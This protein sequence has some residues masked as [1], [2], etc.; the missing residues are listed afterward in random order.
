MGRP[1]QRL[2]ILNSWH[3]S[4]LPGKSQHLISHEQPLDNTANF[5][6]AAHL[7]AGHAAVGMW[8]DCGVGGRS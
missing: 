4:Y 1:W 5:A 2:V 8:P 6:T 7:R 3:R